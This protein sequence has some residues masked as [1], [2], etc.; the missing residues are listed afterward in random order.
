MVECFH[1]PC[2]GPYLELKLTFSFNSCKNDEFDLV[3]RSNFLLKSGEDLGRCEESFRT[4]M[5]MRKGYDSIKFSCLKKLNG[6]TFLLSWLRPGA[7]ALFE[8][9]GVP[10]AAFWLLQPEHLPF[11]GELWWHMRRRPV[12]SAVSDKENLV[13]S[14]VYMIFQHKLQINVFTPWGKQ[15]RAPLSQLALT[16]LSCFGAGRPHCCS[17]GRGG[18]WSLSLCSWEQLCLLC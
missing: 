8:L 18:V 11:W 7:G 12:F 1:Q 10:A 13:G 16:W 5:Y 4:C 14:Y 6:A 9:H 17:C 3:S 2:F 15:G